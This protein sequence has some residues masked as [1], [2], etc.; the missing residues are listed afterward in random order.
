MTRAYGPAC[1]GITAFVTVGLACMIA[2]DLRGPRPVPAGIIDPPVVTAPVAAMRPAPALTAPAAEAPALADETYYAQLRA[3]VRWVQSRLGKGELIT[4]DYDTRLLLAKSAAQRAGLDEVGLSFRDVYGVINAETSWVPRTGQSRN[5]TPNLGIAQFEPATARALGLRNPE[6][7]VEAV[8]AAARHM[9]DAALWSAERIAGLKLGAAEH[10]LKLR[11]GVSVYYNLSSRGRA[12]W[13]G[14]N[15][16]QLPTQTQRHIANSRTG[17]QEA[18]LLDGQL[19]AVKFS[20]DG[21]KAVVT[22]GLAPAGG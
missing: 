8:H 15:T 9:K 17:A 18:A 14:R 1:W 19:Q 21:A 16:H 3:S 7:L 5:G 13:N 20:R 12:A 2:R 4:P 6:D 11:E 10:A 22:A